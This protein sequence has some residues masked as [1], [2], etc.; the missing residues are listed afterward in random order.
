MYF[1]ET[2]D[3]VPEGVGFTAF[4]SLHLIW[5]LACLIFT[6]AF[7]LF[8]KRWSEKGRSIWR[9]AMAIALVVTEIYKQTFLLI[10]GTWLPSYIPLHLCSI[11]IFVIAWHAFKP[12]YLSG[13][14]LYTVCIPGAAA[15]LLFPSW[16]SLPLANFMHIHSFT[17]HLCLLAYPIVLTVAGEI[18]PDIR[19]VPKCLLILVVMAVAI[20]FLNK[21]LDA[22]FF[23]L[24]EAE[25]GNPLVWFE[26]NWGNH[27]F[28][29]PVLL[30]AIIAAMHGPWLVARKIRKKA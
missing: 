26:Q 2:V 25:E 28:G 21:P 29:F 14:F 10:G 24:A 16:T 17:V 4:G 9:K 27:L 20:Y 18:R 5:L 19:T 23:F 30:T 1:W 13:N 3:T 8:Y 15:A 11:N 12:G 22:N 6:V 7:A